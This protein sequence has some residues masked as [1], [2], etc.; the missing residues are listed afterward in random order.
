MGY[1]FLLIL[2][3]AVEGEECQ[4]RVRL[5][6]TRDLKLLYNKRFAYLSLSYL[7]TVADLPSVILCG[8][9]LQFLSLSTFS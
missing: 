6:L 9:K 1:S 7:A 3:E 5:C 8:Q 4:W 2:H